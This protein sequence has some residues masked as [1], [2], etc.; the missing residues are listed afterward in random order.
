M[1]GL[2]VLLFLVALFSWMYER[3]VGAGWLW[4]AEEEDNDER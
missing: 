1:S 4:P 2:L 3:G